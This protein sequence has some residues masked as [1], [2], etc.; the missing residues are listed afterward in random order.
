MISENTLRSISHIFCGDEGDYYS[1][2][3]G[4]KL[5]AFF[6]KYFQSNDVYGQ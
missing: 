2:K 3:Q 6:N 1:Y 5:V 4:Y